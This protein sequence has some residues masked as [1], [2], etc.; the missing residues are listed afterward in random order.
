MTLQIAIVLITLV[1]TFVLMAMEITTPNAIILC[2]LAFLM[3]IGILSPSDALEGFANDGLAT[4]GLMYIIAYAIAKSNFISHL[5]DRTLGNGKSE[6]FSLLRLL[7][8]VSIFSPFIN[9]TPIV[10][11]LT[12]M[13]QKWCKEKNL[14]VSKFLIPLSY[15]TILSGL[16]TVLGTSTNLVAQGLL[17]KYHLRQFGFFDFA[18]VGIPITVVGILY[19]MTIGYHLLPSYK[20]SNVDSVIASPNDYLIEMTISSDF[21]FLGQTISQAGLRH[22]D[23]VFLVAVNR[24]GHPIVPVNENVRLKDKDRLYFTGSIKEINDLLQIPGLLPSTEKINMVDVTNEHAHLVELSI[25][26]SSALINQTVKSS[27]F[28]DAYGGVIVAIHRDS[29]K[30]NGQIG[31]I[32]LKAGD[33][34]VAITNDEPEQLD[35]MKDLHVVNVQ[36]AQSN[37]R[38]YRDFLPVFLLICAIV[39]STMGVMDLFVALAVVCV[40]LFLT[41]CITVQDVAQA[42][43]I[44]V[45]LLVASSYGLG[46][47][48]SNVGADKFIAHQLTAVTGAPNPI[49]YMFLLYFM[50]NFLTAILSNAAALSLMFPIV[51]SAAKFM[52]LPVMMLAMLITIAATADFSTP[53]GYQTNLIVYGPGHYKFTDYFKVGIPLNLICMVICVFVTYYVYI[54]L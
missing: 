44:N 2:A 12:P 11:T 5:F 47:A 26:D 43:D 9:N 34:L 36:L 27:K 15:V 8:S 52:N 29:V 32:S 38:N 7:T 49:L 3:M 17:S 30:L 45:L 54:V 40:I 35:A 28:R 24:N 48:M 23:N 41:K 37:K 21:P 13:V 39:V 46:L 51:V 1:V 22:L 10:S 6:K 20:N 16:I 25:P 19:L 18:V 53:I 31:K 33:D 42:V 50:T 4:I 14:S